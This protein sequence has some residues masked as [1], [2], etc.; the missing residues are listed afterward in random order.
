MRNWGGAVVIKDS[1]I[2][3]KLLE[4]IIT[5]IND[6]KKL[7]DL[8]NNVRKFSLPDAAE[9]IAKRVIKLAEEI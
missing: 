5:T 9:N 8:K 2:S 4:T 1:E 6:E 7:L 3:I